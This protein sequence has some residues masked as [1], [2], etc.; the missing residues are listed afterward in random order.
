MR[1]HKRTTAEDAAFTMKRSQVDASD[2]C[3]GLALERLAD[4][5]RDLPEDPTLTFA[6]ANIRW[7]F[8]GEG[9][10]AH[11]MFAALAKSMATDRQ[12]WAEVVKSAGIKVQR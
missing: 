8:L 4:G 9:L 10:L 1:F 5:L 6:E 7:A 2:G 12:K 3:V 11:R